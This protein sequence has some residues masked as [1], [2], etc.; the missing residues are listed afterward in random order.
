MKS[1]KD[2]LYLRPK[3]YVQGKT[4]Q[5]KPHASAGAGSEDPVILRPSEPYEVVRLLQYT[6]RDIPNNITFLGR[7]ALTANPEAQTQIEVSPGE[8][9]ILDTAAGLRGS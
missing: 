8:H 9:H 4:H 5:R 3:N 7:T 2:W 6:R 1:Q